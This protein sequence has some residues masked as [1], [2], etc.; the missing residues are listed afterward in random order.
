MM[1]S[2]VTLTHITEA[3]SARASAFDK[4]KRDQERDERTEFQFIMNS[5]SP[6]LYD[7]QLERIKQRTS[8]EAGKWLENDKHFSE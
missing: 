2:E 5:L 7:A 1:D 6:Q 8:I 3:Y 4:Y